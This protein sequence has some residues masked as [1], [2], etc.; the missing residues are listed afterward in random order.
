MKYAR[1]AAL[2]L[3][4]AVAHLA[5]LTRADLKEID[6]AELS[7]NAKGQASPNAGNFRILVSPQR[8]KR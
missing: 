7:A 6:W 5:T 8:R 2:L 1:V 3:Y 4:V